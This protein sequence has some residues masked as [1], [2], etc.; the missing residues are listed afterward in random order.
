MTMLSSSGTRGTGGADGSG[1]GGGVY[2]VGT[3]TFDA[4]T[5]I[6]KNEASTSNDD[7]FG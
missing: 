5:T 2:N 7:I 4:A 3:L 6:K 1:V